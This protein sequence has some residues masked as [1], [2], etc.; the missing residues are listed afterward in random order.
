MNPTHHEP[1][2]TTKLKLKLR[3]WKNS[4]NTCQKSSLWSSRLQTLTAPEVSDSKKACPLTYILP[5]NGPD[6]MMM[7]S[8]C[9]PYL[10]IYEDSAFYAI[11]DVHP[12]SFLDNPGPWYRLAKPNHL[13]DV[14][15]FLQ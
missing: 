3:S 11:H 12:T 8:K 7:R 6:P 15:A 1:L 5:R 2:W 9:I 14:A 13:K 10:V 4:L